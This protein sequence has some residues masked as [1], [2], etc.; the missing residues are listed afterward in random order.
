VA[1]QGIDRDDDPLL[2]AGEHDVSAK[3]VPMPLW[4]VAKI[5]AEAIRRRE[6]SAEY[7]TPNLITTLCTEIE[8]LHAKLKRVDR[9]RR[10]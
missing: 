10:R 3:R 9:E 5:H 7:G 2:H 6:A 1:D 8:R 4:Y